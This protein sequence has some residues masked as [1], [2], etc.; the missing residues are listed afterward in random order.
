MFSNKL[1]LLFALCSMIS[2]AQTL[3]DTP[4]AKPSEDALCEGVRT[5]DVCPATGRVY[6]KDLFLVDEREATWREAAVT[7][8]MIF[9]AAVLVGGTIAD[10]QTT[11]SCLQRGSCVESNPLFGKH[12]N[13]AKMYAIAMPLDALL[14]YVAVDRKKQ[15]KGLLPFTAL[16]VTGL[17]HIVVA[18][19]NRSY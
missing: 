14:F 13:S 7:P 2:R 15:G 6:F 8:G 5:G 4:K 1:I 19:H 3:P 16:Y 11:K 18:A 17:A 10:I 9:G 12:P